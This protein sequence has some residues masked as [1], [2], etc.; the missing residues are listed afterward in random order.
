[1]RSAPVEGLDIHHFAR[2]RAG[3]GT[4]SMKRLCSSMVTIRCSALRTLPL[5]PTFERGVHLW[6]LLSATGGRDATI[7]VEWDGVAA[8]PVGVF[9]EAGETRYVGFVARWAG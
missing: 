7:I 9:A 3:D 1:M 2:E 4:K 5:S 6:R 8:S